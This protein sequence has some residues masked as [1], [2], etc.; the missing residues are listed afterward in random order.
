MG[1]SFLAPVFFA[2]LAAIVIPILVHLTHRE[3]KDPLR[4]PS[5]MFVRRVPIRV[6]RRQRIRNWLIFL[7]RVA[8]VALLAAAFARPLLDRGG[9]A[10][11]F[12][13]A[14]EVVVL[15]DRSASMAYANRWS[16][17][18]DA[19]RDAIDAIGPEDRA[20][21]VLFDDRAEAV[22]QPSSDPAVLRA[23]LDQA[24]VGYETTSYGPAIQLAS[25]IVGRSDRPRAQVVLISDFQ[26]SG[27]DPAQAVRLPETAR[28]ELLDLSD[29]RVANLAVTGAS[30]VRGRSGDRQLLTVVAQIANHGS[31]ATSDLPVTLE[32]EGEAIE[33][34]PVDIPAGETARVEFEPFVASTRLQLGL[35]RAG[36][37][38]LA[39]DNVFRFVATP[40]EPI[41][42]LIIRPPGVGPDHDLYLTRALRIGREPEFA[43]SGVTAGALGQADLDGQDVVVLNDAPFPDDAVGERLSRQLEEGTGLLV[44]LGSRTPPAAWPAKGLEALPVAFGG[45]VDQ[46]DGTRLGYLDYDHPALQRFR[47]PRSGDFTAARFFRHRRLEPSEAADALGRFDDGSPALIEGALGDGRIIVFASDVT[48]FWNDLVVQPIFLPFVHE[49]VKYLAGF[50]EPAPAARVGA[51]VD[52]AART[53][54]WEET[55]ADQGEL[56]LESPDGARRVMRPDTDSPLLRLDEAGFYRL[57]AVGDEGIGGLRIAVNLEPAESDLR[58]VDP[59]ELAVAVA[60]PGAEAESTAGVVLTAGERERRQ[61][62]WRYLLVAAAAL[63]LLET[64]VANRASARSRARVV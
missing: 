43:V 41:S 55:A 49:L 52:V 51:V 12:S 63:L 33:S 34:R 24:S 23:A 31:R 5:L 53:P 2:G 54:L 29:G 56:V 35:V 19:A 18:V 7:M 25:E 16:R 45:A 37:D 61:G 30:L 57:G 10:V 44:V 11:T 47:T 62:L 3:R 40:A 42:V 32:L 21:L 46:S 20:T 4:F 9:T 26:A 64:I 50:S 36:D 28:L 38:A 17:A 59:E 14:R 48:N 39:A 1:L 13:G 6:A 60:A 15:L 58:P 27:W 22:T 8:A